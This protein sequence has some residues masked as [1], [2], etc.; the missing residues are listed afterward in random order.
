MG[1]VRG[2]GETLPASPGSF[3]SAWSMYAARIGSLT[4]SRSIQQ[5][6]GRS[7][8]RFSVKSGCIPVHH[9]DRRGALHVRALHVD[10]QLRLLR[11]ILDHD[12]PTVEIGRP[13]PHDPLQLDLLV[14]IDHREHE[15]AER[16]RRRLPHAPDRF[17]RRQEVEALACTIRHRHAQS[18]ARSGGQHRDRVRMTGRC[19]TMERVE[20]H[21]GIA[22]TVAPEI[23]CGLLLRSHSTSTS[24]METTPRS[25]RPSSGTRI[26]KPS[27]SRIALSSAASRLTQAR[28]SRSEKRPSSLTR[29][30]KR[31]EERLLLV[32]RRPSTGAPVRSRLPTSPAPP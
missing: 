11:A 18:I 29:D 14:E 30:E 12:G 2:K 21:R 17:D 6:N 5:K 22:D 15:V 25:S 20:A 10:P 26:A 27:R 19:D 16:R 8:T 4:P 32:V 9:G 3:Q 1:I 31:R 13:H 24:R 7:M 23:S 28:S